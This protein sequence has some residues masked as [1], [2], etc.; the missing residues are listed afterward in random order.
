MTV[1][2]ASVPTKI[3]TALQQKCKIPAKSAVELDI[4]SFIIPAKFARASAAPELQIQELCTDRPTEIKTTLENKTKNTVLPLPPEK[5]EQ[6]IT[7]LLLINQTRNRKQKLRD[8]KKWILSHFFQSCFHFLSL[9]MPLKS[10]QPIFLEE[11]EKRK[12]KTKFATTILICTTYLLL[13]YLKTKKQEIILLPRKS[14]IQ[15]NARKHSV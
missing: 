13:L 11:E 8:A 4:F 14:W 1:G 5:C 12:E 2:D 15:N 7:I 3:W 10:N 6:S 9:V